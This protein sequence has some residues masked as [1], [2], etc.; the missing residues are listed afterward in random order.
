MKM[1]SGLCVTEDAFLSMGLGHSVGHLVL[2]VL[3]KGLRGDGTAG[4]PPPS[5]TR[6]MGTLPARLL[7]FCRERRE[8]VGHFGYWKYA[9]KRL[10]RIHG[11]FH[12][13]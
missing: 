4:S 7:Q 6:L 12:L 3:L 5:H 11:D 8:R 2:D 10:M 9:R 13:K 1:R